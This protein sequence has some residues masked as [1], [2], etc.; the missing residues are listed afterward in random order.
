MDKEKRN[1][2]I[3]VSLVIIVFGGFYYA[4]LPE[5][6]GDYECFRQNMIECSPAEYVNEESE[7]SWG[8]EIMG[9]KIDKC[10]IEVTLLLAKEG[11]LSLQEFEGSSMNCY[12]PLGTAAFP[13]EDLSVCEGK[14]KENLQTRLIEKLYEYILNNLGE[15]RGE[16]GV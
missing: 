12:Y 5:K 9:E 14:L 1:L 2:I 10:E 11:E 15:I 3:A 16:L 6:C 8:Y 4:Y 7:A 13:D